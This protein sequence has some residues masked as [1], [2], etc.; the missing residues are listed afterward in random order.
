MELL[1]TCFFVVYLKETLIILRIKF[2]NKKIYEENLFQNLKHSKL[3]K[4][5]KLSDN[6][7]K[8]IYAIKFLTHLVSCSIARW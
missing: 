1:C 8:H 3:Q 7:L 6:K 4:L 2:I 5:G